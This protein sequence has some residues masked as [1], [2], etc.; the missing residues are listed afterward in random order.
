MLL[1]FALYAGDAARMAAPYRNLF[2]WLSA[3]L[4]VISPLGRRILEAIDG[5]P[6]IDREIFNLVRV[7]GVSLADAAQAV[8]MSKRTVQ[9]RLGRILPH[10]WGILGGAVPPQG[11]ERQSSITLQ[12]RF[13]IARAAAGEQ[14]PS[15]A[16]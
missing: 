12:P 5:L 3:I 1:A 6:P 2:R 14:P 10:L 16:A 15:Y 13:I 11:T 8:G 9:R 7:G 4:G